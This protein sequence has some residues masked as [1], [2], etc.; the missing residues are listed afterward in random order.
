MG[1]VDA[2]QGMEFDVVFLSVVRT[3]KKAN[4]GFLTSF[5]RMC[6][7]MSRQKRA[8]IVVGDAEFATTEEARKGDAIPALA[9]FYDL[10]AGTCKEQDNNGYGVVLEWNV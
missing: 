3:N 5:N 9:E 2:F 6:V 4:F 7:S 1:T 10:C 8:L